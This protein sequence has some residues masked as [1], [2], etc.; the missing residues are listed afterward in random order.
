MV[1]LPIHLASEAKV[2]ELVQYRWMYPIEWYLHTL[3]SY[4]RNKSRPEGSIAKGYIVEECTTFCSRYLHD[5]ETKHDREER[6]Y[7]IENN[8]TNGGGLT[9][10]KCMGRTIGKSTSRVL[11]TEEWSQAHLYVLTNCE[12]VTSFIEEH[13]QSIRVKPRIR[14]R[15]VYLIHTREF[16]SWFEEHISHKRTRKGKKTQN[17][18]VVVI[19][20]V[21]SFASARDKNPIPGH[22]S[23]YG[24]LTDVIELHYLGGNR[25][26]LFKCDWWDVIN[27]GRG[28]K[29]DE[30]EFTCLNFERTICIDE[31]FVIASQAKQVFYVQNSN[32]ENWH[33]VVEIQTRGVYDMNQKEMSL[34]R[35]RVQIVSPEH[36]LDNLQQLLDIQPAATTTPSSSNSS[37]SSDP[38]D[39]S[40]PFVVEGKLFMM[41]KGK[42]YQAIWEHWCDLNT[43]YPSKFKIGIMLVKM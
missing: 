40:D 9:I 30:Y 8:I 29:K 41:E 32:E 42:D 27:S 23:Y 22:V 24:V 37:D 6:N 5:V 21:S 19:A 4:V 1:H 38:S 17:S 2:A 31:P 18:G 12:E 15:D 16:I 39:P 20:E 3:K 28:I 26:I 13:K 7:V 10:F 34:R 14:A 33:T 35:G 36:E 43:M 11:S 25:V